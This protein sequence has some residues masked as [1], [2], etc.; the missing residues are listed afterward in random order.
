MFGRIGRERGWPPVTKERYLDEVRNGSLYVGSPET[1]ARKIA[2][3]VGALGLARFDMKYATGP[4]P[5]DQ[6]MEGIRLYGEQVIPM[7]R[8]MVAAKSAA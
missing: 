4:M 5:H 1:V 3:T 2:G 7:V 8:E 6:L